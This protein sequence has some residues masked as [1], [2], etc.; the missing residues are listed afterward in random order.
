MSQTLQKLFTDAKATKSVHPDQ[1]DGFAF[2]VTCGRLI[3]FAQLIEN[4][5][6]V[7]DR[8]HVYT[9]EPGDMLAFTE[10]K[11]KDILLTFAVDPETEVLQLPIDVF[12][13]IEEKDEFTTALTSWKKECGAEGDSFSLD[14]FYDS[15]VIKCKDADALFDTRIQKRIQREAI[16]TKTLTTNLASVLDMKQVTDIE[17]SSEPAVAQAIRKV[18][19]N[20]GIKIPEH[21]TVDEKSVITPLDQVAMQSKFR[22]RKIRLVN[23]WADGESGS[24]FTHTKVDRYPV[25]L[26]RHR[27]KYVATTYFPDKMPVTNTA[28]KEFSKTLEVNGWTLYRT[29]PTRVLKLRDILS[30]S[31][32]GCTYDFSIIL[33]ITVILSFVNLLAPY[34]TG[35]LVSSVI[36]QA[37]HNQLLILALMLLAAAFSQAMLGAGTAFASMR[38]EARAGYATLAAFLDRVLS[39]PA[40]FFRSYSSGDLAQRIMGIESIRRALTTAT[41]TPV[42]HAIYSVSYLGM[43]FYYSAT[44][45]LW[46]IVFVVLLII[47]MLVTGFIQIHYQ[48]QIQ[49]SRGELDGLL[50]QLFTS[51]EKIRVASAESRMF[52]RW[53][54]LFQHQRIAQFKSLLANNV[55]LTFNAGISAISTIVVYYVYVNNVLASDSESSA[56]STGAFLAFSAAFAGVLSSGVALGS[57]I[58]PLLTITPIY[59]RLKPIMETVPEATVLGEMTELKGKVAAKGI[60]FQY[61]TAETITLDNVSIEAKP[62]Q[63]IAI[64]GPSGSGKSTLLKML[65]GME[66]ASQGDIFYDDIALQSLD[67]RFVRRQIGTVMQDTRIMTT[68]IMQMLLGTTTLTLDDA[69]A[70]AKIVGIDKDIEAMPMQMFTIVQDGTISGGQKQRIMIARAIIHK[71]RI[72]FLDEA[73]SALDQISQKHVTDSIDALHCTR[74]VIAHRLSTIMKADCIYVLVDGKITEHGTYDE[75]MKNNAEFAELA[76]R[77]LVAPGEDLK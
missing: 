66:V 56:V 28:T 3:L 59:K 77:Q 39:L 16:E 4:G 22:T 8:I 5:K 49:D 45:A 67:A 37:N 43:I 11:N 71:P 76:K 54:N 69:W 33:L 40:P 1:V 13:T 25:S 36:P 57:A 23:E 20:A 27:D 42:L 61:E 46:A 48:R 17:T 74:I 31:F 10:N 65:L 9:K 14:E 73:T 75:L 29:F 51:I 68:S 19:T 52:S 47:V 62:G 34:A 60:S 58:T 26:H 24:I 72:L 70:A 7:G 53:A 15:L 21:L 35:E 6:L 2:L 30:F 44:L 38:I 64:V 63:F 55:L 32:K 12:N 18:A 41:I 50:R